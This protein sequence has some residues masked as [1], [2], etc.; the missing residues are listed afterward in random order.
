MVTTNGP[1]LNFL[2]SKDVPMEAA[3]SDFAAWSVVSW[4]KQS[5]SE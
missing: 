4:N 3:L 2:Q 5:E 1:E